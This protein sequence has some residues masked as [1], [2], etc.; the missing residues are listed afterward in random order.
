[1]KINIIVPFIPLKPGG[2]LRVMFEYANHLSYLG[3]D[4]T[5]YFPGKISFLGGGRLSYI[6][7]LY[8]RLIYTYNVKWFKFDN[9][10][11]VKF[12]YTVTNSSISN[13]DV[14]FSTWWSLIYDIKKLSRDKGVVFN[15]VQDIEKWEGFADKVLQSYT[16]TDSFNIV[17]ANYLFGYLNDVTGV[18]PFKVPFAIDNSK[19]FI[20][21]FI[22]ERNA[23]RICMLYSTEPRKGTSFGMD[24]LTKLK[25]EI[26][27]LEV[28]LFGITPRPGNLPKWIEYNENPTDLNDIYNSCSIFVGPSVQEGCALPPME[29]M[30]CGCAIVCTNIDGHKDY[31]FHNDTALLTNNDSDSIFEAVKFLV[32]NHELRQSIAKRGNE[33]IRRFTWKTST[34][35][36]LD[37][38]ES[39]LK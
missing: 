11:N 27:Q 38:F 32:S 18:A 21:S 29:A 13:G 7:Y 2:G 1:M 24:A 15:L 26:P 8:K 4:V 22:K 28:A 23:F 36:L 5:V 39:K 35:E 33:F 30:H 25:S 14:I 34:R 37:I 19:F 9:K 16:L 6:K 17:I 20:K 10:V 12:I 3:N 31:A